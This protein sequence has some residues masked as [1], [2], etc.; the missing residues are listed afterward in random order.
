MNV[1]A[2]FEA[3]L[4]NLKL[5]SEQTSDGDTKH[6]GVRSCLNR[7]YYSLNSETANRMLVGSWGK[8]TRVRPPRDIDVLFTLPFS[9]YQRFEQRPGNKQSQLLQEVK[10]ILKS[11]YP[12]T[13]ISGD[14]QV[15]AVP[16]ASYHVEVVPAIALQ[17]GQFWICDT[18]DGG[19]YKTTDPVAEI[20]AVNASDAASKGNTRHLIRMMKCW[21]GYCTVPMKSF[22]LELLAIDFMRTWPHAGHTSVYYDWMTRDFFAFLVTKAGWGVTVPGTQETIWLGDVWKSRAESALARASRACDNESQNYPC[23]AGEEWQKIFGTYVPMC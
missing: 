17:G 13:D 10:G 22:W 20:A 8:T 19:R 12:S 14:G 5:T 16:F 6:K 9:V 2:R 15:V 11:S 4:E 1:G 7:H 18:H 21:Q 23:L 3:L